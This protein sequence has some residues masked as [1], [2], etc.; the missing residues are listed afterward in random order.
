M[1]FVY[2]I[3]DPEVD[4]DVQIYAQTAIFKQITTKKANTITATDEYHLFVIVL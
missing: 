2:I 4:I 1:H 3:T